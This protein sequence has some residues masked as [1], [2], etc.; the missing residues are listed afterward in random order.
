MCVRARARMCVCVCVCG[1]ISQ[2]SYQSVV[3]RRTIN[4]VI[5]GPRDNI[6]GAYRNGESV[7]INVVFSR[8]IDLCVHITQS[9]K[10]TVTQ[11]QMNS[12]TKGPPSGTS[13][14]TNETDNRQQ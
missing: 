1:L 10:K 6:N 12:R 5:H 4:K 14:L 13:T 11:Q 9:L 8:F 2:P 7:E 3:S